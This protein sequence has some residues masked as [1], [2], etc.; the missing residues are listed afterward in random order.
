MDDYLDIE[1]V[2][3]NFVNMRYDFIFFIVKSKKKLCLVFKICL[4]NVLKRIFVVILYMGY[5]KIIK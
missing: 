2:L 1:I 5:L 3:E 4:K